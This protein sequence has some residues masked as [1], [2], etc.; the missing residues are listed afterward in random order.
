[1]IFRYSTEVDHGIRST[2]DKQTKETES[3]K[4]RIFSEMKAMMTE[5]NCSVLK[6]DQPADS[7]PQCSS[8]DPYCHQLLS[9]ISD[10]MSDGNHL[11]NPL[12]PLLTSDSHPYNP[13]LTLDSYKP[14][15]TSDSHLCDPLLTLDSYKSMLTSDSH[16]CDPLLTLDSHPCDLLLTSDSH[17]YEPMLTSDPYKPM[18]TSDSDSHLC[19]PLL[20][21]DSH[22]Q[23]SRIAKKDCFENISFVSNMDTGGSPS[24]STR[25]LGDEAGKT[26]IPSFSCAEYP[27]STGME[28]I[29]F[30]TDDRNSDDDDGDCGIDDNNNNNEILWTNYSQT[31]KTKS[32][33]KC[34][35][36]FLKYSEISSE[37]QMDDN[38]CVLKKEDHRA[39]SQFAE[40]IYSVENIS[41]EAQPGDSF[42]AK[43]DMG[44]SQS[45]NIL[46]ALVEE[47]GK[48][49]VPSSSFNDCVDSYEANCLPSTGL[50]ITNFSTEDRIL[51]DDDGDCGAGDDSEIL[52]TNDIQT[53]KTESTIKCESSF[54]K[55][56]EIGAEKQMDDNCESSCRPST[57][58]G[59]AKDEDSLVH[60]GNDGRNSDDDGAVDDDKSFSDV[61]QE[62]N[63]GILQVVKSRVDEDMIGCFESIETAVN[64][65]DIK[66]EEDNKNTSCI[67]KQSDIPNYGNFFAFMFL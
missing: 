55:F 28:I 53:G 42:I 67:E 13:M 27:P 36:S 57:K 10:K 5:D 24:L 16:L 3:T 22:L 50:G 39:D 19:D 59:I 51:S 66:V 41:K 62:V 17:P 31:E 12:D 48:S 30:S 46:H 32:T 6:E 14:M 52:W 21:S 54:I 60:S 11:C 33:I 23:S 4:F 45:L 44:S 1:M 20:A 26:A 8:S 64:N 2:K 9:F 47:S 29:D 38:S 40:E 49:A 63:S 43:V 61:I 58:M 35:S 37:K 56:S 65:D 15:L 7:L 34:E 25:A 18:L